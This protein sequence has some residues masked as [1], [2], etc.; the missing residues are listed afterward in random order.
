MKWVL[1][2]SFALAAQISMAS[3]S[4]LVDQIQEALERVDHMYTDKNLLGREAGLF[5]NGKVDIES[6]NTWVVD[7]YLGAFLS[8]QSTEDA[9]QTVYSLIYYSNEAKHYRE[10]NHLPDRPVPRVEVYPSI[11]NYWIGKNELIDLFTEFKKSGLIDS[12]GSREI[13]FP[14]LARITT[15]YVNDRLADKSIAIAKAHAAEVARLE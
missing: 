4:L 6:I 11:E 2:I 3:Q 8:E 15:T 5:K 7:S 13:L 10:K 12:R 14:V 9:F 1:G